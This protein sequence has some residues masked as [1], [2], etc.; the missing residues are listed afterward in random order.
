MA[1]Y[2]G[3]DA[4]ARL[5]QAR[6]YVRHRRINALIHETATDGHGVAAQLRAY[7]RAGFRVEVMI[8][9]VPAAMSNQGIISRYLEQVAGQGH[10]RL[11]VQANA[12]RAYLRGTRPG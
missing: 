10:G 3:P 5:A 7:R 9:A 12:D 1:R 11:S 4:W 6:E 8:L 2:L